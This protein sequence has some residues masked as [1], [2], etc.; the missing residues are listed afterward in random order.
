M[1][2]VCDPSL[3]LGRLSDEIEGNRFA[4]VLVASISAYDGAGAGEDTGAGTLK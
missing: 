1:S 4:A 3:I 2:I